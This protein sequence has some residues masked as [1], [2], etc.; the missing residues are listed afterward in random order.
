[1]TPTHDVVIVGA[2]PAG[3]SAALVLGRARMRTLLVD[4]GPARN[5]SALA[6]HGWIGH[7]GVSP[8]E[9]RGRG[10]ADLARYPSVDVIDGRVASLARETSGV[11]VELASGAVLRARRVILATGI[12]DVLPKLAGLRE[13]WGRDAFSCAHCHGFE[14]ADMTWAVLAL[15]RGVARTVLPLRAWARELVLLLHGRTDVPE[16][17]LAPLRAAGVRIEARAVTRV[18]AEDGAL[19][20]VEL[21]GGEHV[22]CGALFLHPAARSSDVA[23]YAGLALDERGLVRSDAVGETSMPR[24]HVVGDAAGRRTNALSAATDGAQVAMSLVEML[25]AERF[26][27]T[28][29]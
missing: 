27:A 5:A 18:V 4:G 28:S 15:E 3:L 19:R 14:H 26:G 11:R 25:T 20:G 23:L 12:V 1:M 22:A 2:G 13:V 21:E 6:T 16:S 10:R 7:D 9:L 24:V 8:D 17:E 29:S